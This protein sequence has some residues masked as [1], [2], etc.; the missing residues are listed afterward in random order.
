MSAYPLTNSQYRV[1][2]TLG[3]LSCSMVF[4]RPASE[5]VWTF[6]FLAV[7]AADRVRAQSAAWRRARAAAAPEPMVSGSRVRLEPQPEPER[8]P[9]PELPAGPAAQRQSSGETLTPGG[10]TRLLQPDALNQKYTQGA[11]Q[12]PRLAPQ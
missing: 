6:R 5:A 10:Q 4:S 3:P 1:V 11:K 8:E 2:D 9:E 12:G 7:A